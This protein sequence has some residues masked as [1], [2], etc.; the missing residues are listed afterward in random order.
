MPGHVG[1]ETAGPR[2]DTEHEHE[3]ASGGEPGGALYEG[4]IDALKDI[5]DP[6]IPVILVTG[7]AEVPLAVEAIRKGATKYTNV[8][9]TA[10]LKAAIVAK[11]ARDNRLTYTP[12]PADPAADAQSQPQ[13]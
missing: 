13:S 2:E 12:P 6:E 10:E 3:P 8:D 4:V 9:G 11:F 7:H 1:Q 5:F